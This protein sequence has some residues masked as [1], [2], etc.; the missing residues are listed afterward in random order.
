[1]IFWL[2][3][4]AGNSHTNTQADAIRM[5]VQVQAFG[6]ATN[7]EINDMTFYRYKLIN[8]ATTPIDS[9]FFAMWVD[10]DLGCFTDDYIGCNVERSLMYVYNED[11]LDGTTGCDCPTGS[12]PVPTYCDEVPVLGV[13]YFRG[14]RGPIRAVDTFNINNPLPEIVANVYDTI[15]CLNDSLCILEVDTLGELGMSSFTYYMNG[16]VGNWPQGMTDPQ[17]G[18][19]IEFYRYMSG[20]WRDGTPF[21]FGGTGYI[22]PPGDRIDYAFPNDPQSQAGW[23]M[24]T[25]GLDFGDRRTIQ[26]SGPFRL[27]PGAVNELIVGAVWVA[28]QLYPC[29]DL[30]ELY[31]A[32]DLAQA[33]F[34]NCFILPDGP[35][36]PDLDFIELDRELIMIL[37]N[38]EASSNNAFELYAETGLE[39]PEGVEDSLYRFEGYKVFQ[40]SGPEVGPADLDNI[41]KSR[42][43]FQVDKRNGISSLYNWKSIPNPT[44]STSNPDLWIPEEQVMGADAGIFHTFQ[45]T[46]DQFAAENKRLVN[47]R[48]YYYMAVAYA[49][50]NYTPFDAF[51][52]VGQRR[53]YLEGRNNVRQYN[54]MPHLPVYTKVNSIYGEEP[55]VTRL[56]GEGAG[57]NFLEVDPET[58]DV[59]GTPA[60]TG[61]VKY[62]PGASPVRIKVVNPLSVSEGSFILE[63]FDQDNDP[64]VL[65][66]N[67]YVAFLSRGQPE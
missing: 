62:L 26:A 53:T 43:I 32:D 65:S 13:D 47:H 30:A 34:N 35:D 2:Y 52:T 33:L 67:A 3:N 50:N 23:S 36:A 8:R 61:E 49:Y 25:A 42:I 20:S 45:I 31:S 29:P 58:I 59:I 60:F 55:I 51:T 54:P 57:E 44:P 7:D 40:L 12:G 63:F 21:S 11:E 6:Y 56:S 39:I 37:T 46:D 1:M 22:V 15:Q 64:D 48:N 16:S 19:P 9:T 17:T 4:D 10:P 24:C 66:P 5:E 38:D 41:E 14:P 28:D 27:D 18:A